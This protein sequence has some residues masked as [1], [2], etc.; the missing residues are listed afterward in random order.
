MKAA[1]SHAMD[2][3][4][5]RKQR[6]LR[7]AAAERSEMVRVMGD[8]R[9]AAAVA[10]GGVAGMAWGLLRRTPWVAPVLAVLPQLRRPAPRYALLGTGSAL[11]VWKA[12]D[13]L[14]KRVEKTPDV[15]AGP[16]LPP[17]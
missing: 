6:L 5:L 3:R 9:R 13:W 1:G 16:A 7:N 2:Q 17:D 4:V 8:T 10:K 11:L 14:K 15:A 12:Y